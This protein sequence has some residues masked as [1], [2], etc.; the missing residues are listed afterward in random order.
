MWKTAKLY[1]KNFSKKVKQ[2]FKILFLKPKGC[3]A[4][5]YVFIYT[6]APKGEND[7]EV[8]CYFSNDKDALI[9]HANEVIP[10]SGNEVVYAGSF[11]FYYDFYVK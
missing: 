7:K 6:T 3:N 9:Q 5:K 4:S 8:F 10:I 1:E 11:K 2:I